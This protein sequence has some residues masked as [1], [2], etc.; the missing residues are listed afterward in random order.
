MYSERYEAAKKEFINCM[1]FG[2]V[3]LGVPFVIAYKEWW[4]IMKEEKQKAIAA[5]ITS[6]NDPANLK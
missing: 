1:V 2:I 4:P 3:G 6:R 5:S